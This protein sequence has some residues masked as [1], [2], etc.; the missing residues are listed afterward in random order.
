MARREKKPISTM[1]GLLRAMIREYGS[2]KT[3]AI[4]RCIRSTPP[5]IYVEEFFDDGK[6]HSG[7]FTSDR[8]DV[9]PELFER[10]LHAHYLSGKLEPGYVSDWEF[11]ITDSGRD[12]YWRRKRIANTSLKLLAS[13]ESARFDHL[14]CSLSHIDSLSEEVAQ[15]ILGWLVSEGYVGS[16][17]HAGRPCYFLAMGGVI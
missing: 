9:V 3:G 2:R 7:A 5:E 1:M 8:A 10:A 13:G 15:D 6:G 12:E 4:L 11:E 16:H 14:Y 17:E